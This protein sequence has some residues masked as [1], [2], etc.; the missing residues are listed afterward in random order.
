MQVP[1]V[2]GPV[3]IAD[4][5]F[6]NKKIYEC[7]NIKLAGDILIIIDFA[8]SCLSRGNNINLKIDRFWLRIGQGERR[9]NWKNIGKKVVGDTGFALC[10]FYQV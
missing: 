7:R 3:K 1:V 9:N 2:A 6:N 4:M 10:D 8:P 5:D